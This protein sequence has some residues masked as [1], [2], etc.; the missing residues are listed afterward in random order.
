MLLQIHTPE[1]H[2]PSLTQDL[3]ARTLVPTDPFC[4]HGG[5]P[6]LIGGLSIAQI[7]ETLSSL[8]TSLK[9]DALAVIILMDITDLSLPLCF[10]EEDLQPIFQETGVGTLTNTFN[11][12]SFAPFKQ[13][14]RIPIF[15]NH[16]DL[17]RIVYQ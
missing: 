12:D 4:N 5:A 17:K 11:S 14:S 2:G 16:K 10:G 6:A 15:L 1:K 9:D 3:S 13:D 7:S 8:E